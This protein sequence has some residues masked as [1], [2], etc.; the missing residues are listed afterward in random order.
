MC[1]LVVC[2][3][4]SHGKIWAVAQVVRTLVLGS[5]MSVSSV[6]RVAAMLALD[7]YTGALGEL[8]LEAALLTYLLN[9]KVNERVIVSYCLVCYC[10]SV[11]V[12]EWQ[13]SLPSVR[14]CPSHVASDTTSTD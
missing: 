5:E 2:F 3:S 11:A 12:L 9:Y 14:A 8:A 4:L 6:Y 7:K 1:C 13:T 10:Y